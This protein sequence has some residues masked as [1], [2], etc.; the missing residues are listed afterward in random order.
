MRTKKT[1]VFLAIL[2]CLL[3]LTSV[4]QAVGLNAD[5]TNRLITAQEIT[6]FLIDG[7][8]DSALALMDD[9]MKGALKGQ[10]TLIWP[11]ITSLAGDFEGFGEYRISSVENYLVVELALRFSRL[12]MIQTTSFNEAGQISGLF[13]K[14][15]QITA[16]S[17][18][19]PDGVT[20][21]EVTVDA[22]E[23]YPLQGLLTLPAD[24]FA[25]IVLVHGS[26]PLDMDSTVGAN[27]PFRDLAYGLATHGIAVL[28]YEKRT[29]VYAHQMMEDPNFQ[30]LTVDE[31]MVHDA[32]A[33]LLLLK[34]TPELEGKPIFLL[35]H[36][37][38]GMMASYIGSEGVTPAGYVILAGSPRKLW[39]ISA[40]QNLAFADQMEK[41]GDLKEAER[42]RNFVETETARAK[43]LLN[44]SDEE[45]L[46]PG[47]AVFGLGDNAWYLRHQISIDAAALH[48]QDQ[49]PV[50]IV[51][52]EKDRQVTL[53]D[54]NAWKEQLKDH[55]AATFEL[56]PELNHLF[57]EYEGDDV[58]LH[59]LVTVEY[60]ASTPVGSN[61]ISDIAS[62]LKT[63]AESN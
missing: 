63:V 61:L 3:L 27:K 21:K 12:N 20:E 60:G 57:G 56:Y 58:P 48:M 36:S 13:I 42:I 49:L 11:Q 6:S 39:E 30:S 25:G 10:F 37:M 50:F 26:G 24:P 2:V 29:H 4:T 8:E 14:P 23:G 59:E 54:F 31:E 38:G 52:G 1:S 35:G 62:W 44:L 28:R 5:E 51:Q 55:P 16:E 45:A 40:A 43:K 18:P 9:Q 17:L 46:A 34:E 53:T 15:G 33:A 19:L 32:R 47:S 7:D 41:D 22:A